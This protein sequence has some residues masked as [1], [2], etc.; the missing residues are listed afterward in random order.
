VVKTVG[1]AY[2]RFAQ[3]RSTGTPGQEASFVNSKEQPLK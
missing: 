1:L 3:N 2:D